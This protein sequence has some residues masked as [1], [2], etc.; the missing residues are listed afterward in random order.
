MRIELP[1][2]KSIANRVLIRK[3]LR[4]EDVRPFMGANMPEDVRV[5]AACLSAAAP[6]RLDVKDSGTAMRFLTA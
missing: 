3:A 4:G 2:S 5:M 1:I 6:S